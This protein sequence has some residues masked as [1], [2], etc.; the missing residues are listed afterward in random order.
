MITASKDRDARVPVGALAMQFTSGQLRAGRFQMNP[1]VICLAAVIF[2]ASMTAFGCAQFDPYRPLTIGYK[3]GSIE[4][5]IAECFS[6]K[7]QEHGKRQ[8]YGKP[9]EELFPCED[10]EGAP[11]GKHAVQRRHYEYMNYHRDGKSERAQADYHLAFVEFDDQGWFAD[12]KQM[13]ALF[14]TLHRLEQEEKRRTGGHL[15]ILLYA[16]GWKHDVSQ[17]DNNVICFSRLLERVDILERN[18]QTTDK[19]RRV[20]GVYVGWRGLSV[21]GGPLSNISFWTRKSAAERVG[22]GGVTELLTRLNEYRAMRNPKRDE[23]KTQLVITGH[24]FGGLII[25][26]ALSHALMERATNMG[27]IRGADCVESGDSAGP[28]LSCYRTATSFGDLVVLVNPA[29]EGSQYEPLYHIAT[30]RCYNARQ[31]PVLL[32]VTSEGDQAT[33]LAFPL[34][35]KV[36]TLT[37]RARSSDQEE[38]ILKTVGHAARYQTHKLLWNPP[39]GAKGTPERQP[40]PEER[41][42]GCP[43]LTP[44]VDFNWRKFV[45]PLRPLLKQATQQSR[46]S[47]IGQ[48]E[49]GERFY[50]IYSGDVLLIGDGKYSANYP[51]LVVRTDSKIIPDH[52][53]IYSEPFIQFLHSFFLLHIANE[54]PFEADRCW[55]ANEVPACPLDGLIPCEQSCRHAD[56]RSCSGRTMDGIAAP[57]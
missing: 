55:R 35:R 24:S 16:H 51:Y 15:L 49:G 21:K 11:A 45:E 47:V 32:T 36:S 10:S 43:Y 30:N 44:T 12:R 19:D 41:D 29:L 26:S 56:G 18:F 25:Y 6:G 20:V 48:E 5:M 34:G 7:R 13:E 22:R 14:M 40:A 46:S 54:L 9:E 53:T 1:Q 52:N 31:R 23:D 50:R 38:A 33:G 57:P 4:P 2:A 3:N 27:M 17:C 39:S 28:R 42:C 8:E 37:E